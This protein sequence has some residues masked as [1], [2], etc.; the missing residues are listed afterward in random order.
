MTGLVVMDPSTKPMGASEAA[1]PWVGELMGDL[2]PEPAEPAV[3]TVRFSDEA[4]VRYFDREQAPERVARPAMDLAEDAA[5]QRASGLRWKLFKLF[6]IM[7]ALMFTGVVVFAPF[8]RIWPLAVLELA[9]SAIA[10]IAWAFKKAQEIGLTSRH[11]RWPRI[12]RMGRFGAM[13]HD[14]AETLTE[15]V[16]ES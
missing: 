16:I 8:Q 6:Y 1:F 12:P 5:D 11:A 14:D 3:R 7:V 15:I 2:M 13:A 10:A 9:I 4:Q